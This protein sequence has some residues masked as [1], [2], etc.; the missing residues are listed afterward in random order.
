MRRGCKTQ[1]LLARTLPRGPATRPGVWH[2][3]LLCAVAA[4][5]AEGGLGSLEEGAHGM[6]H[7]QQRVLFLK[8]HASSVARLCG[9]L[10]ARRWD[11]PR[12]RGN[13][14]DDSQQHSRLRP[15]ESPWLTT[16]GWDTYCPGMILLHFTKNPSQ[17]RS[18]GVWV[19]QPQRLLCCPLNNYSEKQTEQTQT[20]LLGGVPSSGSPGAPPCQW[21]PSPRPQETV[22]LYLM[23]RYGPKA[24]KL[25]ADG[26]DPY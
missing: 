13:G 19:L 15:L 20:L 6:G 5:E 8:N 18:A 23:E 21:W 24:L 14:L 2:C 22:S 4:L 10:T 3:P 9:N 1:L 17:R 11:A 26:L 16:S 25:R 7:R 12:P